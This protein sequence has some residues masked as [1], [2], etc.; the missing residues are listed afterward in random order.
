M[1]DRT[2]S[3]I[4]R[5]AISQVLTRDLIASDGLRQAFSASGIEA[6]PLERVEASLDAIL[7]KAM[8]SEGVFVFGYGSLVWNPCIHVA[9]TRLAT[10]YGRH[11]SLA[12]RTT[13]GR[14]TPEHPGLMLSLSPGGSCRGLLL[15]IERAH[16]RD[17][18]LLLWRRE[19]IAG[20]YVPRVLNA[21]VA[22]RL[23]PTIVFDANPAHPNFCPPM[24]IADAARMIAAASGFNGPNADYMHLTL[25]A[26]T[27][28]GIR[29]RMLERLCRLLP[30]NPASTGDRHA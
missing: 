11:R 8:T 22:S 9:D 18:L 10:V 16:A 19:M 20:S 4:V 14:G 15:R 23:I 30:A 26:L 2:C 17:E 5:P 7:P 12:L 6:W 21:R 13:F 29:D 27:A 28:H 3:G 25:A 1:D 24:P